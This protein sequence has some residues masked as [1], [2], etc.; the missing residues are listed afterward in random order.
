M[1]ILLNKEDYTFTNAIFWGNCYKHWQKVEWSSWSLVHFPI[2]AIEL[3]PVFGQIASLCE[4]IFARYVYSLNKSSEKFSCSEIKSRKV[5]V[6]EIPD[7]V[8]IPYQGSNAE[9]IVFKID[10]TPLTDKEYLE[11][12]LPVLQLQF[13]RNKEIEDS[14]TSNQL[15]DLD[16]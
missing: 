2:A 5:T 1:N 14:L 7:E 16:C 9:Y 6:V 3:V 12:A 8:K 4:L 11:H 15:D 13:P 10:H